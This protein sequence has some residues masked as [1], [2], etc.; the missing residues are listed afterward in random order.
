VAR[1]LLQLPAELE[2]LFDEFEVE[3]VAKQRLVFGDD[4][5]T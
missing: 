5:V 4:L 1:V 3:D 2:R